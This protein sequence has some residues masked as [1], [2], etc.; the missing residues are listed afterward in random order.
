MNNIAVS[1]NG[2][3]H[4][5]LCHVFLCMGFGRFNVAKNWHNSVYPIS[6][7]EVAVTRCLLMSNRAL[8][9]RHN[10]V[11]C[12]FNLEHLHTVHKKVIRK[13]E[14]PCVLYQSFIQSLAVEAKIEN[15]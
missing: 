7:I 2:S 15:I 5:I 1:N 6:D 12:S 10:D 14:T 3:Q 8:V 11:Y 13:K 4:S 9:S